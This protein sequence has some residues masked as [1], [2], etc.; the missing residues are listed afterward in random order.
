MPDVYATI[1]EAEPA[2]LERLVNAMEVRAA[3]PAQAAMLESY[4]AEVGFP[5]GARVLEIG[6]GSGAIA[7]VLARRRDVAEVVGVDPSPYFVARAREL[8]GGIA[9]L[10]F[11]EADGRALPFE[12]ATFDVVVIH[13]VLSHVPEP[14]TVI[15]EADRVVKPDGAIAIFD[16]DYATATVAGGDFDP[17]QA[18]IDAA[19]A[20]LANDRWV[21]RRLASLVGAAGLSVERFRSHGY[22]ETT[23][24]YVMTVIDRGADFLESGGRISTELAEALKAEARTRVDQ[25]AFFGH[26]AY[27]S[28]IARKPAWTA[29]PTQRH[30]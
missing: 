15:A 28:L 9:G 17:L 24:D 20:S 13:T 11:E 2:I 23:S 3:Q 29:E 19:F 14:D 26:I 22:V 25:G 30:T 10:T 4:L 27:A 16:G 5:S 18:C 1:T 6:S 7:R 21:V 8:S 12:A